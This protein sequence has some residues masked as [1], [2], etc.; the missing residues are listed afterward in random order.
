MDTPTRD[1]LHKLLQLCSES[2]V[3]AV[4]SF[5]L[6]LSLSLSLSQSELFH[7]TKQKE[8]TETKR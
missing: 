1:R 2:V 4:L 7:H 3:T 8:K 5:S 6:S